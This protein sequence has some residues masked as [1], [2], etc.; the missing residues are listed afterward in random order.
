MAIG[1][2]QEG[3]SPRQPRDR[4]TLRNAHPRRHPRSTVAGDSDQARLGGD[5]SDQVPQVWSVNRRIGRYR[6]HAHS[7]RPH[8]PDDRHGLRAHSP[9][10]P[11]SIDVY[12]AVY[13]LFDL[14]RT[15]VSRVAGF[16]HFS[17]PHCAAPGQG[18]VP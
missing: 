15:I 16:T 6:A 1:P 13:R 12:E 18:W 8:S 4:F 7:P 3:L 11:L 17:P 10:S 14:P 5:L 2:E 9:D